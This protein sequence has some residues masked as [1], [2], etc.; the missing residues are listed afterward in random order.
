VDVAM[1]GR[2]ALDLAFASLDE[3]PSRHV[4]TGGG[5]VTAQPHLNHHCKHTNAHNMLFVCEFCTRNYQSCALARCQHGPLRAGP[6]G[7]IPLPFHRTTE[8][9]N[10]L[11]LST[12][13]KRWTHHAQQQQ[14]PLSVVDHTANFF[15]R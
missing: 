6:S 11:K 15:A 13:A 8:I 9:L 5:S 3:G 7:S 12:V 10:S 1:T 14:C 4:N 2:V